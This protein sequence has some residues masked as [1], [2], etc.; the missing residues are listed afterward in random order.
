VSNLMRAHGNDVVVAMLVDADKLQ[1]RSGAINIPDHWIRLL[2]PIVISG[3]Q[4]T[5]R[6]YSWGGEH[7]FVY[8]EDGFEDVLFEFVVGA[9]RAGISL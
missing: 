9:R 5:V 7:T 1:H 6:V 3:D 2:E 4:I 8:D